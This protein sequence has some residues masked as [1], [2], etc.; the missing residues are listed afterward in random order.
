MQRKL[1]NPRDIMKLT[2]N[3]VGVL[4]K[5]RRSCNHVN[6]E[7]ENEQ[8]VSKNT[9]DLLEEWPAAKPTITPLNVDVNP[10]NNTNTAL[11]EDWSSSWKNIVM[12]YIDH[13]SLKHAVQ[14][15]NKKRD[16]AIEKDELDITLRNYDVRSSKYKNKTKRRVEDSITTVTS[17]SSSNFS[18][19]MLKKCPT[20]Y[21]PKKVKVD[22]DDDTGHVRRNSVDFECVNQSLKAIN[23]S[24]SL[25]DTVENNESTSKGKQDV[26]VKHDNKLHDDDHSMRKLNNH[27]HNETFRTHV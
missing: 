4:S 2:N 7:T 12:D 14:E 15:A 5:N 22:S 24:S 20:S 19:D 11:L 26:I 10:T 13:D 21:R 9:N 27:N 25:D 16:S 6:D 18:N 17:S 3:I 23:I 1:I 8:N